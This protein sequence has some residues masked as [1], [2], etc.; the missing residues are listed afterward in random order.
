[1]AELE[2]NC[3]KTYRALCREGVIKR[4]LLVAALMQCKLRERTKSRSFNEKLEGSSFRDG[5]SRKT[6]TS[7]KSC[8]TSPKR[9]YL[10][11]VLDDPRYGGESA[12]GLGE[13]G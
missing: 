6:T 12:K 5:D 4:N 10:D 13:R 1:M 9:V 7:L 11:E 3:L 8:R 2:A